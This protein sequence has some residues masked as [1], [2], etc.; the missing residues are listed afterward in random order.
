[1]RWFMSTRMNE[2]ELRE[3]IKETTNFVIADWMRR[4]RNKNKQYRKLR[5]KRMVKL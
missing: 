1:M 3:L 5:R 2:K 4:K